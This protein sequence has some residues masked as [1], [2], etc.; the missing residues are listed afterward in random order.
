MPW[1][2]P[3]TFVPLQTLTA[4][5]MN[6]LSGLLTELW[7]VTAAGDL[8]YA[9]ASD[10]LGNL[11]VGAAGKIVVSNGSLPIYAGPLAYSKRQGGDASVWNTPGNTT[12]TP[13]DALVQYGAEQISIVADTSGSKAVT[14]PTAFSDKPLVITGHKN[15]LGD[16]GIGNYVYDFG[17][18]VPAT[19]G[20]TA[21]IVLADAETIDIPF[22]WIAI[23]PP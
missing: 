22:Y 5:V 14:F 10:E 19:T 9:T 18:N 15:Q 11:A 8:I 12:Y 17:T 6:E 23:G 21:S 2:T 3:P 7:P 1:S 20:F 4:D 16:M 13:T